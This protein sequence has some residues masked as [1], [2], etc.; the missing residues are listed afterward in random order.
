[1]LIDLPFRAVLSFCTHLHGVVIQ[2]HLIQADQTLFDDG[3]NLI[4]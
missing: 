2:V 4:S 1:M 3:H